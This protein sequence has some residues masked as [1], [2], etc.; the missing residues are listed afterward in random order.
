MSKHGDCKYVCED[1]YGMRIHHTVD[2]RKSLRLFIRNFTSQRDRD[3]MRVKGSAQIL[4][5]I[6]ED[7]FYETWE[8]YE[9]HPLD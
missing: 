1:V 5:K 6:F 3:F 7:R 8:M 4:E 2:E 9:T